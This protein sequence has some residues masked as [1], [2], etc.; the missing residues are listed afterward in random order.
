MLSIIILYLAVIIP[1]IFLHYF[2]DYPY[3]SD[4]QK[5]KDLSEKPKMEYL[6]DEIE[7]LSRHK[8]SSEAILYSFF[9]A[10]PI[11]SL[12][13]KASKTLNINGVA[14]KVIVAGVFLAVYI[15]ACVISSAVYKKCR[16]KFK[17][18]LSEVTFSQLEGIVEELRKKHYY[19]KAIYTILFFVY[20]ICSIDWI[21]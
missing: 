14:G 21:W 6:F 3:V 11:L 7:K 17:Y 1:V 18:N 4:I 10:F 8:S 20:I 16:K 2:C 5:P 13:L 12:S 19:S 15:F 9:F